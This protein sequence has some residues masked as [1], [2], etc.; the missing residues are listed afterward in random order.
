MLDTAKL[1]I[2]VEG[3][4][5]HP[6]TFTWKQFRTDNKRNARL[7]A[8]VEEAVEAGEPVRWGGESGSKFILTAAAFLAA[9][10]APALASAHEGAA[11]VHAA[12]GAVVHLDGGILLAVGV[13]AASIGFKVWALCK[14]F[15]AVR[16]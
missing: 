10:V 8:E 12:S 3:D 9:L 5:K 2:T 11:H 7:L 13:A 14:A 6:L 15:S 4:E 16:S 1:T